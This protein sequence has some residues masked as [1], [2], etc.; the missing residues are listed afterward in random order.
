MAYC[1]WSSCNWMCDVYVYADVS[2]GWTTHVAG[3]KRAFPPIPDIPW[4]WLP[5]FGAKWNREERR[6]EYPDRWHKLAA[7]IVN[8]LAY[9]WNRVHMGSLH[10]IPLR[11]IGGGHDGE[12]FS[13]ATALE[14]A[15][16]L[17]YLR[18][19]GYNVPQYAI[20]ALRA[21]DPMEGA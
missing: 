15:E 12:S 3:R 17:E 10:L 21:E 19:C 2:G 11:P 6:I 18:R 9:W 16:R 20:N 8:R 4:G 5:Q 13:D 14:C 1:R 7:A